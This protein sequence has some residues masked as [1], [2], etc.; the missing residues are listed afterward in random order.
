M[1]SICSENPALCWPTI[2]L[3][4]RSFYPVSQWTQ[5]SKRNSTGKELD[6]HAGRLALD[7]EMT[8]YNDVAVNSRGQVILKA[9]NHTIRLISRT[10]EGRTVELEQPK[11]FDEVT[12]HCVEGLAV[13]KNDKVY[14]LRF[15]TIKTEHFATL[16]VLDGNYNII[17][18]CQLDFLKALCTMAISKNNDVIIRQNPYVYICDD[19]GQLKHKF[20]T[21]TSTYRDLPTLCINYENNE[22]VTSNIYTRDVQ[23]YTEK[24]NLKLTIKLPEGHEV[25]SVA[26]HRVMCKIVILT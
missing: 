4:D 10:G 2:K 5:I 24:G 12:H 16:Y 9:N 8:I 17:H 19:V 7:E 6:Q 18:A 15:L 14:V 1:L 25:V 26:F 3:S 21:F 22:I 11:E 20:V 13:D 23:T